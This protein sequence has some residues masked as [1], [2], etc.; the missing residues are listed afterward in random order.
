MRQIESSAQTNRPGRGRVRNVADSADPATQAWEASTSA[1]CRRPAA[2]RPAALRKAYR[3]N[4]VSARSHLRWGP[5][6][7]EA[8]LHE[9]RVIIHRTRIA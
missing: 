9:P 2:G 1:R 6:P 3:P 5:V 8:L 7:V 4:A